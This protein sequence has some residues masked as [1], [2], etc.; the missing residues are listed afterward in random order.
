MMRT[1]FVKRVRKARITAKMRPTKVPPI[2]T[3][4]KDAGI[5]AYKIKNTNK[6]NSQQLGVKETTDTFCAY[7]LL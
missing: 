1:F 6:K 2:L 3:T 4:R 7:Q 5:I